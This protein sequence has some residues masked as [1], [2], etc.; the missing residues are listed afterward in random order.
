M[1]G[2]VVAQADFSVI[3]NQE[4]CFFH[5]YAASKMTSA[6]HLVAPPALNDFQHPCP[7]CTLKVYLL[8]SVF[9][10]KNIFAT[11]VQ[12]LPGWF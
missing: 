4:L 5:C 1:C 6:T 11:V 10:N 3:L 2:Q 12:F 9:G 7:V 8:M